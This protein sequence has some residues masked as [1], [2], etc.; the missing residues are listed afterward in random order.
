M[1]C[2][3]AANSGIR[4][5]HDVSP[6]NHVNTAMKNIWF[7]D[8]YKINCSYVINIDFIVPLKFLIVIGFVTIPTTVQWWCKSVYFKATHVFTLLIINTPVYR[9][10]PPFYI[11]VYV[12]IVNRKRTVGV[13]L[14]RR[15]QSRGGSAWIC[16]CLYV[17]YARTCRS[18]LCV[19]VCLLEFWR[20]ARTRDDAMLWP[21]AL[22]T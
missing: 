15:E 7:V 1:Y 3:N 18:V 5:H 13:K 17:V 16:M 6:H 11:L 22:P 14:Q 10:I 2:H 19:C 21:W 4:T 20:K 9:Y 12:K 8:W